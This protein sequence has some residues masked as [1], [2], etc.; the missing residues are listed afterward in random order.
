MENGVILWVDDEIDLL[1]PH[2]IFLKT[3][4]YQVDTINNGAEAIERVQQKVFDIVF[5]D[6]QM[7]GLSGIE[8]LERIKNIA[9]NL[10]VVMITKSEEERIME[11]AIGSNISDYLIK[12]VNPNQILLCLK[13]NLETK[14]LVS[15]KNT[16][17]YQQEFRT[18]GMEISGNPGFAR[19]VEIYK[20]LTGFDIKLGRTDDSSMQDVLSM[21]KEEANHAFYK[22]IERNY[23]QWL[24]GTTENR[25]VMSHTLL[26]DHVFPLFDEEDSPLFFVV[27]DNLRYDQWKRLQPVFEELFRVKT[28]EIY[29]SILPTTTM[30]AR[31]A[32]FAGLLPSEIKKKYPNYW[33][34]EDEEESKNLYEAELLTENLKRH[35]KKIRNSYHKILNQTAA[36]KFLDILP[37]LMQNKFNVIVYNFVDMLSHSRTE[38]EIIRELAS[39]ELAYRSLTLSWFQHSPLL[40]I[41]KYIAEKGARLVLTTDHG[42]IRVKDPVK[43]V[44]DK[45]TNTNLRYK[46]GRSLNFNPKEVFSVRN[47]EDIFLPRI[48]VSSSFIFGY[49]ADFLV[50]PNN[51]NYYV[52]YYKNTFQH[53]GVSLEE[54]LIPFIVM[55]PK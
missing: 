52:N 6:E 8:T 51:Y 15:E 24:Q 31:N 19:W 10:P 11:D 13:K 2:I 41:V 49:K 47:P 14:K 39:D 34:D 35:G 16:F 46:V 33:V 3:K 36:R 44:G 17:D 54:M 50:Y 7:P 25:P 4:G 29:S 38:M 40:E 21:Q 20:K 45:N 27:V 32:M 18:I 48:N 1:K 42:S 43:V 55:Q 12:P 28:E 22:Y 37:N 26:K 5:L 9:P 23:I 30:Y 53:G